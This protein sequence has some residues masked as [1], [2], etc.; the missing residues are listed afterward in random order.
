MEDLYLAGEPGTISEASLLIRIKFNPDYLYA[1]I[2]RACLLE[3]FEQDEEDPDSLFEEC[4]NA[5]Q[6]WNNGG[7]EY[8]VAQYM[9]SGEVTQIQVTFSQPQIKTGEFKKV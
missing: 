5:K 8:L 7:Y 6:V 1:L 3:S 4:F 9:N 2:G